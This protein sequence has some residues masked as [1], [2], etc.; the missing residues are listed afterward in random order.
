MIIIDEEIKT[1]KKLMKE[2]K[3]SINDVESIEIKWESIFRDKAFPK[4]KI[5]FKK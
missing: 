5:K 1:I 2:L 4:I 3:F